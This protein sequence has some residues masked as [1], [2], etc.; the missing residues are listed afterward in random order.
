MY[1]TDNTPSTT[2][3]LSMASGEYIVVELGDGTYGVQIERPDAPPSTV[4]RF[5]TKAEADAFIAKQNR[6]KRPATPPGSRG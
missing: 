4:F 3:Q 2:S 1:I 5:G 6:K